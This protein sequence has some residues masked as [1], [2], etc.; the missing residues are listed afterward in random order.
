M[1]LDPRSISVSVAVICFFAIAVVGWISDISM[2]TCC[3]RAIMAAI[4]TYVVTVLAV[5][6]INTILIDAMVKNQMNKQKEKTSDRGD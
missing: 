4:I 1:P 2:F 5:K 3:K 6:T